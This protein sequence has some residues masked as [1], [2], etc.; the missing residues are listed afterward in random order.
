M[1]WRVRFAG[2]VLGGQEAIVD[3]RRH[4]ASGWYGPADSLEMDLYLVLGV[5]DDGVLELGVDGDID[6][7]VV[8]R[9]A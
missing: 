6:E 7:D 2:G 8:I 4:G 3:S 9:R 5:A 1:K